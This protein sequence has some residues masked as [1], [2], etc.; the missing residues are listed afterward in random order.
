MNGVIP[1]EV[2]VGEKEKAWEVRIGFE[3]KGRPGVMDIEV[4]C[5]CLFAADAQIMD[6]ARQN[7]D[8][9]RGRTKWTMV[10]RNRY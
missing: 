10:S 5:S 6:E 9:K 1:G 8:H 3:R 4:S 7:G 2:A